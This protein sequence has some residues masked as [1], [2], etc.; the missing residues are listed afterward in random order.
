ML[1]D[2][3]NKYKG[4]MERLDDSR[5]IR[6]ELNFPKRKF[7]LYA[8]YAPPSDNEVI[9]E[10]R[11]SYWRNLYESISMKKDGR[12]IIVA[13]DMNAYY[14]GKRDV[15]SKAERTHRPLKEYVQFINQLG[16]EDMYPYLNPN[17]AGWTFYR[18]AQNE[19][20]YSARIDAILVSQAA[21]ETV[22][23][24][25]VMKSSDVVPGGDH[26]P[27][28][29]CLDRDAIGLIDT[30]TSRP[31][32]C[33]IER[34]DV[35]E[36][37]E[38]KI[39]SY[40]EMLES[41]TTA[42]EIINLAIDNAEIGFEQDDKEFT[43]Q[44]IENANQQIVDM[45]FTTAAAVWKIRK[46]TLGGVIEGESK[47]LRDLRTQSK[48]VSRAIHCIYANKEAAFAMKS[49]RKLAHNDGEYKPSA[50]RSDLK[51]LQ[52]ELHQIE[53]TLREKIK[54]FIDE[55]TKET[56]DE[57]LDELDRKEEAEPRE[58]FRRANPYKKRNQ[59]QIYE[60][61]IIENG[62]LKQVL[63]EKE[64]VKNHIRTFWKSIF[65]KREVHLNGAREWFD[66]ERWKQTKAKVSAS[67][68]IVTEA[69]T[70]EEL[71]LTLRQFKKKTAPGPNRVPIECFIHAPDS[72]LRSIV[73]LYNVVL[74]SAQSP[75]EW[76]KGTIFT[77]FKGGKDADPGQCSNYRPITLLNV[78][79]KVL[80]K[81]IFY[82]MMSLLEEKN[83]ISNAQGG[84][85]KGR[86]THQKIHTLIA[87][88][89]DSIKNKKDIHI[90]YVDFKKA[91][92]SVSHTALFDTLTQM[93]FNE[94]ITNMLKELHERNT[95][96]VITAWGNTKE[97][98]IGRGVRQGDPLAPLLFFDF[99]RAS[100]AV[101]KR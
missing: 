66:S 45:M 11:A 37:S 3:M 64:E 81:M 85:R 23:Q 4:K 32:S 35:T 8:V 33:Q 1:S 92:D 36:M 90:L 59:K 44:S 82:R 24:C 86:A 18:V 27:V 46:I 65:D 12:D 20:M 13:G 38:E 95:C 53:S 14:D 98:D 17:S 6:I 5:S 78:Q 77:L 96:E 29:A 100:A 15:S 10:K 88:I 97:F 57:Y 71:K 34:I 47:E 2:R 67:A 42:L 61:N 83:A 30:R 84:W 89:E 56:I 80:T 39:K 94:T 48:R 22:S 9:G 68:D 76:R 62:Q 72:V 49:W 16:L 19:I 26:R 7:A 40:K 28:L 31:P 69:F 70:L 63:Q 21:V 73:R 60:V 58:F 75:D 43:K 51:K 91:Y 50:D 101:A 79:Y 74:K 87:A 54:S 25:K 99:H 41:Q 93:G 55:E 52:E